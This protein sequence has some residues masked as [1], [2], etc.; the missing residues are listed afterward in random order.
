M[1]F[2]LFSLCIKGTVRYPSQYC[3]EISIWKAEKFGHFKFLQIKPFPT[4]FMGTLVLHEHVWDVMHP[5]TCKM[6]CTTLNSSVMHQRG[7]HSNNVPSHHL[8][9]T[10]MSHW[11]LLSNLV[12]KCILGMQNVWKLVPLSFSFLDPTLI[13]LICHYFLSVHF[14]FLLHQYKEKLLP[15]WFSG[16]VRVWICQIT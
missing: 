14:K 15:H 8:V 2:K 13:T 9:G 10:L 4:Y 7:N 5:I 6:Q 11:W 12:G 1:F 3:T 16:L